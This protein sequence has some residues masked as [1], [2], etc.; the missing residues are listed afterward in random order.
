MKVYLLISTPS[1]DLGCTFQ[2]N[3]C[4]FEVDGDEG[5][6]F[7]RVNGS[8]VPAM[9]GDHTFDPSAVFLYA[10]SDAVADSTEVSY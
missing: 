8:Q 1:L 10:Q 4:D 9:D 3:F 2:E 6:K 7:T 5:F